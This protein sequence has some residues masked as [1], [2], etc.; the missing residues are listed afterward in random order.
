MV[1]IKQ[2]SFVQ[3]EVARGTRDGGIVKNNFHL[4]TLIKNINKQ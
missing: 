1:S 3:R 4:Q 2:A